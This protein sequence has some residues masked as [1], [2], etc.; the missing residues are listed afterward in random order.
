MSFRYAALFLIGVA[1]CAQPPAEPKPATVEGTVLN[2]VT[3]APLRKVDVT[4]ANG[5]MDEAVFTVMAQLKPGAPAPELPKVTTRTLTA[6][7]PPYG[8]RRCGTQYN[9]GTGWRR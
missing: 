2:S 6:S 7:C 1:A 4:L 5:E 9:A 8:Q 3:K